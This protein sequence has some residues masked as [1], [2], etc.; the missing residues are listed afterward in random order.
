M[1]STFFKEILCALAILSVLIVLYFVSGMRVEANTAD[2]LVA[3]I[4]TTSPAAVT[5]SASLVFGTSTCA[6]R[7]ISTTG[8][9]IMIGFGENQGF[10]PTALVGHVQGASTTV[11]YDASQFGCGAVRIYSFAAQTLTV[12]E[13]R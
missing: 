11:T 5:T 8:S 1:T 3:R 4:A 13:A 6:A 7:T 9:A 12:A 2:G 10:V